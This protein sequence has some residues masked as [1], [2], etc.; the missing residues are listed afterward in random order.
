MCD[1]IG[2]NYLG[3]K[4]S[5]VIRLTDVLR[6]LSFLRPYIAILLKTPMSPKSKVGRMIG[7]QK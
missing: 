4:Q 6:R 3:G 7:T 2:K 5:D 1:G